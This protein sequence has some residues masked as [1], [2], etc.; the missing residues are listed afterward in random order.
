M[1]DDYTLTPVSGNPFDPLAA[2]AGIA[3]SGFED[4][5]RPH[6]VPRVDINAQQPSEVPV[7][8]FTMA[9][10]VRPAGQEAATPFVKSALES[11]ANWA[12]VPGRVAQGQ[13][14][15]TPGMWSDE[16]EAVSQLNAAQEP[17][18][19]A[20]TAL[21][22]VGSGTPFAEAGAAGIFGG[23][24]ARESQEQVAPGN[25]LGFHPDLRMIAT[26]VGPIP[27]KPL[28]TQTTTNGNAA[29]QLT[30]LDEVQ[31]AHPDPAESPEA[32]A[33]MHAHAFGSPDVPVPPYAFIRDINS[34]GAANKL[35]TL[36][37]GQIADADHGFENARA[38][39]Q[40]YESGQVSPEQTGKLFLW[41][42]LSRGV[43]PYTQESLFLD[44]YH[45]IDKWVEKAVQGNFTKADMPAY[46]EWASSV[47]PK[48]SGQPGAGA[49]HNL[50][51]FG[52]N[53]L[54]NMAKPVKEGGP[55]RLQYIHD[56]MSDPNMT[57][58]QIRR[59]FLKLGEGTGIDNKVVSFTQLV[60]GHPDVMVLDRV[61]M[62][63]MWDDGRFA[64]RNIYDGVRDKD[65]KIIT[66]TALANLTY[67]ARGLL[68]YEAIENALAKRIHDIYDAVGRPQDAS[69]GRYHWESW[70]AHSQ[71]EA[72]H[73]TLG[74][75]LDQTI[76]K[77]AAKQ[78]EYGAYEYGA[79]YSRPEG[80]PQFSYRTPAGSEYNFS[81][82]AFRGFLEEIKK[83]ASGV[84]PP[85]FKVT[86][87]GNAPWFERPE[88]NKARLDEIANKWSD[89]GRQVSGTPARGQGAG[90]ARGRGL[91][92]AEGQVTGYAKGGTVSAG[93]T[94]T[95]VHGNPF[96][97][98]AKRMADG[99][100]LPMDNYNA[101]NS[102]LSLSPQEQELY[103]RHLSNLYGSGGVD[104]PHDGS[105][106]TL[107][108]MSFGSNGKYYNV[109][110][111]YNGGILSPDD[112]IAA[113]RS[114][115]LANFPSYSSE[116]EAEARYQAMHDYMERDTSQYFNTREPP[117]Q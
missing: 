30:N 32:W 3:P 62:R 106:S 57:G 44:A 54:V 66:G 110:T 34:E 14:P 23:K 29:K 36:T 6:G 116:E 60:A 20:Q 16:D 77:V 86:E 45:G 75:I 59:E 56:L 105:R 51:A 38:F 80:V 112:A 108:Q 83:P 84:I 17:N 46:R 1:P 99:G 39:R 96:A 72:S 76:G 79:K 69:I 114:Q 101:A 18:W 92:T 90:T 61:Q 48:G 102:A 97:P 117:R 103:Q 81:V 37:P 63:N 41:S 42:F 33:R 31:A 115:G 94:L 53:F 35:R 74:A 26:D 55:S 91:P 65:G 109:P 98:K 25:A 73:G 7:E 12:A 21:N 40:A 8:P 52:E 93:Y 58:Q 47:A 107:Y 13:Q 89:V 10:P 78:G 9:Q 95:P 27:E 11:G 50:N 70:V 68:Q 87:S 88:V 4:L 43:S 28:I 111:V 5:P 24:L 22:M 104:N 67:G 19:G 82:P 2:S 49:I 64:D 113:A 85:K 100:P 71:Q 15:Q